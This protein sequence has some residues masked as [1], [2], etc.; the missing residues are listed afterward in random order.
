MGLSHIAIAFFFN[1]LIIGYLIMSYS[2]SRNPD[3]PVTH[4]SPL[5]I[6]GCQES[7]FNLHLLLISA[8]VEMLS[9]NFHHVALLSYEN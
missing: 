3:L 9:F 1:K 5:S 8:H 6:H 7:Q 4:S 2:H